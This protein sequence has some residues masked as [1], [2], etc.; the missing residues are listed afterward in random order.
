M[1]IK[2]ILQQ[3]QAENKKILLYINNNKI[4]THTYYCTHSLTHTKNNNN[5][6]QTQSRHTKKNTLI[7]LRNYNYLQNL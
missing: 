5:R 6:Y 3:Q 7:F 2:N 4:K 1:K